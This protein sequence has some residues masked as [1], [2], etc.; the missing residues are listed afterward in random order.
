[1]NE[2][3]TEV[4]HSKYM[5]NYEVT[6]NRVKLMNCSINLEMTNSYPEGRNMEYEHW[7]SAP[8]ALL[9]TE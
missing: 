4:N 6:V 8:L 3:E 2:Y 7:L 5:N 1:M 9:L